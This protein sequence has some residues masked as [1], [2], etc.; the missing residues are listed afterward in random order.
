MCCSV[1]VDYTSTAGLL[2]FAPGAIVQSFN[3]PI[4]EDTAAE[5]LE[6]FIA[7]LS[8]SEEDRVELSPSSMEIEIVDNDSTCF[9]YSKINLLQPIIFY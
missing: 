1:G 8:T 3:I 6:S 9:M 4:F 2:T 5:G 7:T